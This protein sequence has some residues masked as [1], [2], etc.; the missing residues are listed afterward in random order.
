LGS[1]KNV[2]K[3]VIKHAGAGGLA[4]S[5]NTKNFS[6]LVSTDNV[7]WTTIVNVTN[8]TSSTTTHTIAA[9]SARYIKLNITTPAQ[10]TYP[11]AIIPEFEVY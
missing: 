10:N 5:Y 1:A 7:N 2:S 8:N 6:I 9:R 4:T 3:F 11:Y